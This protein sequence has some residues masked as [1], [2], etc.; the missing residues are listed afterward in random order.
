GHTR[1]VS[2]WSSDVCS[3][4]LVASFDNPNPNLAYEVTGIRCTAEPVAV[5]VGGAHRLMLAQSAPNPF[6]RSCTIGFSTPVTGPANLRIY[7]V[8]GRLVRT[9]VSGVLEAGAHQRVWDGRDE[10]GALVGSG[11]YFY[12][13]MTVSGERS[14]RAV[15]V[16]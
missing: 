6:T 3:S 4:D 5:N 1:L 12:R 10:S 9:L 7:N 11:V 2:D 15:F 8:A 16:R 14:Q 13:L